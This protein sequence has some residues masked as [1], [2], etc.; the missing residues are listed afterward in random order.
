[1]LNKNSWLKLAAAVIAFSVAP[2]FASDV[3]ASALGDLPGVEAF[4]NLVELP[5]VSAPAA[6][7]DKA[8]NPGIAP[9]PG[10]EF[11]P[12]VYDKVRIKSINDLLAL[13]RSGKPLPFDPDGSTFKNKEGRLPQQPAGYYREYTL[14][15]FDAPHK[16]KIGD[17]TYDVAPDLSSRGS[18]RVIIGGGEK[19]YYTPDHYA[20]F[21]LLT[22]VY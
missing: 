21:I 10:K 13:I 9:R 3:K 2:S 20:N 12:T 18:E 6:A 15:T 11:S 7:Q 22:V 4:A 19:I 14:L 17:R 1:M 8:A 16:V 5:A